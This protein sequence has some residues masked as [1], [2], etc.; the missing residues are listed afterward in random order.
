MVRAYIATLY[1]NNNSEI[2]LDES[3]SRLFSERDVHV[4]LLHYRLSNTQ[5]NEVISSRFYNNYNK[6]EGL[7]TT[8]MGVQSNKIIREPSG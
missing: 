5:H 8:T 6:Y 4:I 1:N 3:F 7:S 2:R